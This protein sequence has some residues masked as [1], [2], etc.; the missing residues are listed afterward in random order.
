MP[1]EETKGG[2]YLTF[3]LGEEIYAIDIRSVTEIV[4]M[5]KIT[6]VPESPAF[7]RGIMNLRGKIIPLIDMHL[8]FH[9]PPAEYTDRTCIVIVQ[10]GPLP[11]GLIVDIVNEV[12]ELPDSSIS[13][14]PDFRGVSRSRSISGIGRT[15]DGIRLILDCG[16]LFEASEVE[17]LNQMDQ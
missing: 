5:Q 13:P 9:K 2:K 12:A 6:E 16:R 7:V 1:E 4:G 10:I 3:N 15:S 17:R 11:V 8:K 14:P